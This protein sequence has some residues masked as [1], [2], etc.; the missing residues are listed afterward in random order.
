MKTKAEAATG[1]VQQCVGMTEQ[2]ASGYL[3]G[4]G[5]KMRVMWRDGKSLLGTCDFRTNRVN[6]AIRNGEVLRVM[7][8]G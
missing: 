6:V 5:Y 1:N 4:I 3:T 7:S 8:L 2:E